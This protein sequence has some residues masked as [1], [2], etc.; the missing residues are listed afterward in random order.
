MFINVSEERLQLNMY[1]IKNICLYIYKGLEVYVTKMNI[2]YLWVLGLLG[3][4]FLL[5]FICLY[6]LKF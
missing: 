6:F 5:S 3:V 1:R 2:R 4:S